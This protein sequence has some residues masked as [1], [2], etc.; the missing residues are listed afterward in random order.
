MSKKELNME[1]FIDTGFDVVSNGKIISNFDGFGI[2]V[3]EYKYIPRIGKPQVLDDYRFVKDVE[4]AVW[5]IFYG[6][7]NGNHREFNVTS[8]DLAG[9]VDL[10]WLAFKGVE[11][12]AGLDEWAIPH[13]VPVINVSNNGE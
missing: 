2:D 1:A 4:G 13:V 8:E 3:E 6:S 10:I 12:G 7:Y 9:I 11:A 5:D